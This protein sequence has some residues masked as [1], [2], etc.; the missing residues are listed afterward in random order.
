VFSAD[1]D[2]LLRAWGSQDESDYKFQEH[3][4]L[5]LVDTKLFVIELRSTR[6]QVF[7]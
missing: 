6:V 7:V 1:G 2:T 5:A 3:V 4:V